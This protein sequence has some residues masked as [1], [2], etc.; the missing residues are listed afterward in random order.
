MKGSLP[1]D[2][3][4]RW[5][6]VVLAG[7]RSRRFGEDKALFPYRGRPLLAW[8]WAG[9]AEAEERFVVANRPYPGYPVY[10][11]LYPGGEVLSGLHAALA[12][13]R[14][15]WVA[16]VGC[17]QPFLSVE[18]WRYMRGWL[19]PG[20]LAVVAGW[21]DALEPL[22]AFYH[23]SLLPEVEQR[24]RAGSYSLQRLLREVP[25]RQLSRAGLEARFGRHLFLN[26]NRPQDL[27]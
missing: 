7:G 2:G 13:A 20:V 3:A 10:P 19:A 9:L 22:G 1:Y 25:H 18:Y 11:D 16:V 5:S 17:D 24:L 27:P 14:W 12:H 21:Q 4:V 8:V 26:A 6:G 15:E 23:R